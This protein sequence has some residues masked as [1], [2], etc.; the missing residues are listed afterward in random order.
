MNKAL[1]TNRKNIYENYQSNYHGSSRFKCGVTKIGQRDDRI[2]HEDKQD[3]S[4]IH[5]VTWQHCYK[6]K[7][8]LSHIKKHG[9]PLVGDYIAVSTYL[10]ESLE[11]VWYPPMGV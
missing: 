6:A 5:V 1:S 9:A 10:N 11:Y 8:N 4:E 7:R 2:N 3:W